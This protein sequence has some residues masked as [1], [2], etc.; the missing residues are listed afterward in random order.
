VSVFRLVFGLTLFALV[1]GGGHYYLWARLV[2]DPG[3]P[4]RSGTAAAWFLA[5]MV[6]LLLLG[7]LSR[8]APRNLASPIAYVA[9]SWLGIFFLLLMMTLAGD[10]AKGAFVLF[11]RLSANPQATERRQFIAR[12]FSWGAVA[13]AGV[14]GVSGSVSVLS[15]IRVKRV[16][17]TLAKLALADSGFTI[18]QLTDVHVGPTIGV[19]YIEAVVAQVN[20]LAADAVVITGDLV[21]GSVAELRAHVAPLSRLKAKHG[22]FFVTGNHE[23]YAG[24]PAWVAHLSELGIQVMRNERVDLGAIVLAGVDDMS[25]ASHEAGH[26]EDLRKALHGRA[27]EKPVVLL[28]H[29][30]RVV[31]RAATHGVDLQLSG[32]THGGQIVPWNFFVRLQ[33][34]YVAGLFDHA[35]T[36]LYVSC[37]TGYWGPP[38]RVGAPAEITQVVLLAAKAV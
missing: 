9:F 35:G 24:A 4:G 6:L 1:A 36:Q 31:T 14:L 20:A 10:I 3:W 27:P 15:R 13:S 28:A 22:V 18:V 30:P 34:P 33:Q 26:G 12:V 25:G 5:S 2:R 23:Y 32:H 16:P 37:G 29:Q 8:G 17:V 19:E 38:M 7:F 11:A 21:D